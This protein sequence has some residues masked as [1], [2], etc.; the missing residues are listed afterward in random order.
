MRYHA[1]TLLLA[2]PLLSYC[3]DGR[4]RLSGSVSDTRTQAPLEHVLVEVVSGDSAI[5]STR[6]DAKG[7]YFMEH[8]PKGV[9][10][11]RA[12]NEGYLTFAKYEVKIQN[13]FTTTLDITMEA[14]P[15]AYRPEVTNGKPIDAPPRVD[16]MSVP[17]DL[18]ALQ[19]AGMRLEEAG[20]RRGTAA[21][22]GFGGL[23]LGAG[24][25]LALDASSDSGV[26]IGGAVAGAGLIASTVLTIGAADAERKAGRL[27][28]RAARRQ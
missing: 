8:L 9:F 19:L 4:G 5:A 7:R 6:T 13:G 3:N 14:T 1:L 15:T 22:L 17:M 23:A 26:A 27:L 11:V 16:M 2:L 18:E 25:A 12:S 21:I 20:R 28:Q 24:L 10:M